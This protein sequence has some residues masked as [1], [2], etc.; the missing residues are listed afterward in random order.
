M[1]LTTTFMAGPI[2]GIVDWA[3]RRETALASHAAA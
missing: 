1:A 3:R 2:L